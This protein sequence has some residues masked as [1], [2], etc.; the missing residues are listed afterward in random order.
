V[1][2]A[3]SSAPV[4]VVKVRLA[5]G[6]IVYSVRAAP[7]SVAAVCTVAASVAATTVTFSSF[8]AHVSRRLRVTAPS[9][10]FANSGISFS[11]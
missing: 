5:V 11:F 1:N 8:A 4:G 10:L 9:V 7:A 3:P 6:V 2:A